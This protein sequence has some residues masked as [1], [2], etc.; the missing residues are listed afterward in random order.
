MSTPT[1]RPITHLRSSTYYASGC[2]H[3]CAFGGSCKSVCYDTPTAGPGIPTKVSTRTLSTS[4]PVPSTTAPSQ[5]SAS[6]DTALAWTDLSWKSLTFE[7]HIHTTGTIV[8]TLCC[9]VVLFTFVTKLLTYV[10]N[11]HPSNG[12]ASIPKPPSK[13]I[14]VLL[15]SLSFI[16]AGR[17]GV[18]FETFERP[19]ELK[20]CGHIF[21]ETCIRN[22]LASI[23]YC[24]LDGR[25]LFVSTQPPNP[26]RQQQQR[27]T[28][29]Q[30]G[31]FA[32]LLQGPLI[33]MVS[34]GFLIFSI[35]LWNHYASI[36]ALEFPE[37][38]LILEVLLVLFAPLTFLQ[39]SLLVIQIAMI[40][41]STEALS[42][43]WDGRRRDDGVKIVWV[44]L[45]VIPT[46]LTP[47]AFAAW[48]QVMLNFTVWLPF[49][50]A[51]KVRFGVIPWKLMSRDVL[52]AWWAVL[53][54]AH[55]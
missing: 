46:A 28:A 20:Q 34:F 36:V 5:I 29:A 37:D 41:N 40:H 50:G 12:R 17:C 49:V 21:C 27:P 51:L 2:F 52:A 39:R 35:V 3:I 48:L 54:N 44:V 8:A 14:D 43:L 31:P 33:V 10:L 6:P 23:S 42:D 24:P 15:T 13:L 30:M 45:S 7:E 32:V 18:C 4:T 16:P 26:Q 19:A 22:T 38:P 53:I 9:M 1:A 47:W 11:D 25:E 55:M